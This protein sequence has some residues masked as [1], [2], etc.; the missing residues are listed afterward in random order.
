ML[1]R[2]G[3]LSNQ[4]ESPSLG[5][6]I[7]TASKELRSKTWVRAAGALE[8]AKVCGQGELRSRESMKGARTDAKLQNSEQGPAGLLHVCSVPSGRGTCHQ[9]PSAGSVLQQCQWRSFGDILRPPPS[10]LMP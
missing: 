4:V 1:P 3:L 7:G 10:T 8:E 2:L 5:V 9:V 6:W